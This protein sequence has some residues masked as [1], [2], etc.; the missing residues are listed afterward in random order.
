MQAQPS[1][2]RNT[3]CCH[4][5]LGICFPGALGLNNA[6]EPELA[7]ALPSI[8]QS[9]NEYAATQSTGF[10]TANLPFYPCCNF[11]SA[12]VEVGQFGKLGP[13][14]PATF[15][16]NAL[17]YPATVVE[18]NLARRQQN[19]T[20]VNTTLNSAPVNAPAGTN[21]GAYKAANN[22]SSGNG[23]FETSKPRCHL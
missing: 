13:I 10:F 9:R 15:S 17:L 18:G 1:Q 7:M 22:T 12:P 6:G 19:N 14:T 5:Q 2:R 4:E 8:S 23:L 20:I 3:S 21:N 16:G 11:G